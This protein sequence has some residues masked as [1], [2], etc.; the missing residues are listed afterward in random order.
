MAIS[1]ALWILCFKRSL[2][3]LCSHCEACERMYSM[4]IHVNVFTQCVR[5]VGRISRVVYVGLQ[6]YTVLLNSTT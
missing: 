3:T 2:V 5:V 4:Y 1:R 6:P